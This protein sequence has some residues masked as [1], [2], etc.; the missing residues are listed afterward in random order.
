MEKRLGVLFLKTSS[1]LNYRNLIPRGRK[2]DETVMLSAC[3]DA[4]TGR[5]HLKVQQGDRDFS[6]MD[7][8]GKYLWCFF[9][10]VKMTNIS[11]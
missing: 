6:G 7:G 8:E 5:A 10:S 4:G 1:G 11:P 3:E 2:K 9:T